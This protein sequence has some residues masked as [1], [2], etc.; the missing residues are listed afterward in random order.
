[1]FDEGITIEML[2]TLDRDDLKELGVG[3]WRRSSCRRTSCTRVGARAGA[4]ARGRAHLRHVQLQARVRRSGHNEAHSV[5]T[6]T[7]AHCCP[8]PTAAH[9]CSLL[10]TVATSSSS[11]LSLLPSSHLPVSLLPCS[12]LPVSLLLIATHLTASHLDDDHLGSA[13]LMLCCCCS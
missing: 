6:S 7:P 2:P 9:C 11:H 3:S 1:M 12:R 13:T 10:L 8:L 5:G 4:R